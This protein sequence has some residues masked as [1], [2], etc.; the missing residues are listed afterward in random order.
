MSE[1]TVPSRTNSGAGVGNAAEKTDWFLPAGPQGNPTGTVRETH[2]Q[3]DDESC[4]APSG[5]THSMVDLLGRNR[6]ATHH[7]PSSRPPRRNHARRP[8]ISRGAHRRDQR[9]HRRAPVTI[10]PATPGGRNPARYLDVPPFRPLRQPLRKG[11]GGY[12]PPSAQ[13]THADAA[14]PRTRTFSASATQGR[15]TNTR[16]D[17][18]QQQFF[19]DAATRIKKPRSVNCR[20]FDTGL[21]RWPRLHT[22]RRSPR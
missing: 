9:T 12:P 15:I 6:F 1:F 14:N 4:F 11:C 10:T 21:R 16:T 5:F 3:I 7:D 22:R 8:G 17:I 19:A 18:R 2:D 13:L 20:I